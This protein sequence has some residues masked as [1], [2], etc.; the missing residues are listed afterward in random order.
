ML[1]AVRQ[2]TGEPVA[3]RIGTKFE[4]HYNKILQAALPTPPAGML[5]EKDSPKNLLAGITDA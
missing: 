4:S 2:P 3:S 5:C 1:F